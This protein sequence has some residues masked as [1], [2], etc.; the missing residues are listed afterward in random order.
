[1][2]LLKEGKIRGTAHPSVGQEAVAAGVCG[3]LE[4]RDYI[5]ML[6][7]WKGEVAPALGLGDLG[8]Q[9][10]IAVIAAD[11]SVAG[12]LSGADPMDAVVALLGGATI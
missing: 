1:M 8:D 4:P 10:G 3:V 9:L 11:G 6:P 5:V 12:V 2:P 7:D